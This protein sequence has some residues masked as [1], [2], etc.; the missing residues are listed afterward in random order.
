MF[1]LKNFLLLLLLRNRKIDGSIQIDLHISLDNE[2]CNYGISK[3]V[4]II[5]CVFLKFFDY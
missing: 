5:V 3:S 1:S 2:K 4:L